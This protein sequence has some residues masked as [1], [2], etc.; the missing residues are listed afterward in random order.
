MGDVSF[1][2]QTKFENNM[3]LQLN[4]TKSLLYPTAITRDLKGSEK[5]KVDNLISNGQV[6]RKTARGEVHT[7]D[8]TGF[9]GIWIAED[10]PYYL[11]TFQ[12]TEDQLLT[13]VDLKGAEVMNHSATI[14]RGRDACWLYGF[15][16][17]MIT[18]KT[19]TVNNAFPAAN[20]VAA[21][22]QPDGT[23][24]AACGMN[25][26]K[27]RRMRKIFARNYVDM[28]QTFYIGLT[29]QQIEELSFDAKAINR[30]FTDVT[31]V[32]WSADGKHI[33]SLGGFE[34]I[35][36]EL[37]NPLY[38]TAA[39]LTFDAVNSYRKCP[40]WT[41]DGMVKGVHEE[42][43]MRVEDDYTRH[44]GYQVYSRFKA[45]CSRTDNNRCG[46]ILCKE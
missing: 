16:G 43:Y 35:E 28:A 31:N 15:Y 41:A 40:V 36:I 33:I 12:D 17:N 27:L 11:S 7:Q 32:K 39:D 45:T 4:Q 26:A 6:R 19:G 21:T 3:R 9:D 22:L 46:Y 18:G 38:G 5:A 34:I 29:A 30:D 37:S 23:T 20:I 42:L 44:F 1:T 14:A 25:V 2:A 10:D 24:G 8:T 13:A